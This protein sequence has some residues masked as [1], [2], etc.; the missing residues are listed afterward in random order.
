MHL[1][2]GSRYQLTRLELLLHQ[3]CIEDNAFHT[4]DLLPV[5]DLDTVHLGS[6]QAAGAAITH[7]LGHGSSGYRSDNPL[8]CSNSRLSGVHCFVSN[9]RC[10]WMHSLGGGGLPSL[11]SEY[12]YNLSDRAAHAVA[13]HTMVYVA[14]DGHGESSLHAM[15]LRTLAASELDDGLASVPDVLWLGV[16][17]IPSTQVTAMTSS[18]SHLAIAQIVAPAGGGGD[19]LASKYSVKLFKRVSTVNLYGQMSRFA[20]TTPRQHPNVQHML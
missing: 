18:P 15:S 4:L 8:V 1:A 14:M 17:A 11:V 6:Q 20:Q 16:E 19:S 13:S 5:C 12:V 10:G 9:E 2:E 7:S 3:T